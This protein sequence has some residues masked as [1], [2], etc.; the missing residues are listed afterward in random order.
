MQ[1]NLACLPE[2]KE[3]PDEESS[4]SKL[5]NSF[6]VIWFV[7]ASRSLG[8]MKSKSERPHHISTG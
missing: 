8:W 6:E 5:A 3:Y 7:N 1:D 2:L 4:L